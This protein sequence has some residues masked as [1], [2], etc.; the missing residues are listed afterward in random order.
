M[1]CPLYPYLSAYVDG[2]LEFL[3]TKK[4]KEHVKGCVACR[5]EL[6]FL[7]EIRNGL[8]RAAVSVETPVTLREKILGEAQR[9]WSTGF[10]FRKNLAYAIPLF[11]M[12]LV[13]TI[14]S[15]YYWPR[16]RDSFNLI[17]ANMVNYHS[18][19]ASGERSPG[20]R[21]SNLQDVESWLKGYLDF[22]ILIPHA[23]FAGYA[24]VGGDIFE[25]RGRKFVYLKYQEAG[26]IIG[27]VIYKDSALPIDLPETIDIGEITLHVGKIQETNIGAWKRGGLVYSVLTTE[28]RSELIEYVQKCIQLF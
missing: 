19:Y 13:I 9:G 2:E 26:K 24:L 22:K 7:L 20:I 23:A 4:V 14:A 17:V 10:L 6:N 16:E 28:D 25:Q 1:Q 21:S 3:E 8:K 27:Y 11:A 15:F 18:A 12:L 5:E